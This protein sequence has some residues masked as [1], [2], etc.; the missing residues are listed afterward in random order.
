M[1]IIDCI[2]GSDE[3]FDVKRGKVS[4]SHFKDVLNKSSKS[5]SGRGL[6]M[7]KVAAE[8]LTGQ[9]EE[10]YTNAAMENG[11]DTE[12]EA[13]ECYEHIYH[14]K[15]VQVG[16]VVLNEWVGCSPDG[17]IGEDGLAEIKCPLGSTH[18]DYISKDAMPPVYIPQVQG[19]LWVTGRKWCDYIS[20]NPYFKNRPLWSKR[21][22]R[23]EE[24]IKTLETATNMFTKE[25]KELI[26]KIEKGVF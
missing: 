21:I 6:Y 2:Q 8:I 4:A 20:Y 16:F 15:V 24:Y 18:I 26:A 1:E 19:Q 23:D 25:L 12:A 7:R 11:V 10:T 5:S 22:Q 13:R 14:E 17:L 3:W 9:T